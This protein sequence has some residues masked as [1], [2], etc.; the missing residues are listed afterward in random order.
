MT[1]VEII[2]TLTYQGAQKYINKLAEDQVKQL[3]EDIKECLDSLYDSIKNYDNIEY[4]HINNGPND[5][6]VYV[7]KCVTATEY[8][9]AM[10]RIKKWEVIYGYVWDKLMK[11]DFMRVR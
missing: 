5:S 3:S 1:K 8:Q 4:G 9:K 10:G 2:N 11:T 7:K 6:H